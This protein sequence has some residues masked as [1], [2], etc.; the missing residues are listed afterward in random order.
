M[1]GFSLGQSLSISQSHDLSL[2]QKVELSQKLAATLE[3]VRDGSGLS[4]AKVAIRVWERILKGVKNPQLRE[5][6]RA[7]VS[8]ESLQE[9]MLR[10][11]SLLA[12]PTARTLAEFSLRYIHEMSSSGGSY[13]YARGPKGEV[14]ANQPKTT[15]AFITEVFVNEA[16]FQEK[17]QERQN[18]LKRAG[19]PTEGAFMELHEMQD[20]LTVVGYVRSAVD[21][22][23]QSLKL[24][25]S[26]RDEGGGSLLQNFMTDVTVLGHLDCIASERLQKRFVKRFAGAREYSR[27]ENFEEA[28][29]NTVGE[30]ALISMGIIAPEIF[31]LSRAGVSLEVFEEVAGDLAKDGIKLS[32][33]LSN[34]RLRSEG[35]FFFNRYATR[36]GRP[37]RVTDDLIRQFITRTVREDRRAVLHAVSFEESFFPEI[38]AVVAAA[39]KDEVEETL[40]ERLI[41]L[42]S[43]GDFQVKFLA[44]LR[45]WYKYFDMFYRH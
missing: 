40:R 12:L 29:L 13:T 2:D 23:V 11:S 7:L 1:I 5:A 8:S 39:K 18:M 34:Y 24:L 4:P 28:M 25:L 45:G 30:Y 9:K 33:V 43:G 17:I 6:L 37:S 19:N 21:S 27:P 44:L 26:I 15:L 32:E 22:L 14:L 35:T 42:F 20:A 16:K 36:N 3:A 10:S 38:V 41:D 31:R